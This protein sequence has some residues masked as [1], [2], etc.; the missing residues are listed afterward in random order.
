MNKED[1][2]WQLKFSSSE[3]IYIVTWNNLLKQVF[4]PFRVL[5]LK[6]VGALSKGEVVSVEQVKVTMHLTTVFIIDG[7]AY[8]YYYFDII[9]D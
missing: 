2:A 9:L 6:S 7:S 3:W 1:L 4:T 8:H 5:V